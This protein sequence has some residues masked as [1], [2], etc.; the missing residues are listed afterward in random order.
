MKILVSAG[1]TREFFDSVRFISNP[2]SGRMGYAIAAAARRRGHEVTLVTGPVNIKPP[3]GVKVVPVVTAVE[4][5]VACKRAFRTA[6]AAVMTAAVC[7]YR[8]SVRYRTKT[9]KAHRPKRILLEPTEDIAQALGETKGGRLLIG[10]AMEDAR[11]PKRLAERKL[12]KKHCDLI[13]LNDTGNVAATDATIEIF[14]PSQGWT[15]PFSGT[16]TQIATRLV[17]LIEQRRRQ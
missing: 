7:D 4:M 3:A 6:D 13:V 14:E 16:K 17:K 8:P 10:F 9:P 1:P 12:Q 2:S 11:D 15:G 5:S